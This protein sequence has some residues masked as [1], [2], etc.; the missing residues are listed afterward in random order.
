MA[1][2]DHDEYKNHEG[3]ISSKVASVAVAPAALPTSSWNDR[4]ADGATVPGVTVLAIVR[5]TQEKK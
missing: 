1:A 4:G 3:R 2:H 5:S